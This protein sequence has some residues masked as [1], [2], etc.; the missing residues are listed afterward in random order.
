MFNKEALVYFT[1]YQSQGTRKWPK[2]PSEVIEYGCCLCAH[3]PSDVI[4]FDNHSTTI[5]EDGYT[6]CWSADTPAE[7]TNIA[8]IAVQKVLSFGTD[9]IYSV[10][11]KSM[12]IPLV[13]WRLMRAQDHDKNATRSY[14][15]RLSRISVDLCES[16]HAPSILTFEHRSSFSPNTVGTWLSIPNDKSSDAD[17]EYEDNVLVELWRRLT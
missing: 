7:L 14:L 8:H 16:F 11:P 12:L 17:F 5:P 3:I 1:S 6:E 4:G 10:H 15:E 13:K 9:V 2:T